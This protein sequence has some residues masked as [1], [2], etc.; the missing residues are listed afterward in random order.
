MDAAAIYLRHLHGASLLPHSAFA[1][2]CMP[3]PSHV[4][5]THREDAVFVGI[6]IASEAAERRG[7]LD[8]KIGVIDAF[9]GVTVKEVTVRESEHT[10]ACGYPFRVGESYLVFAR[11][12]HGLY[13]SGICSRT[14]PLA[15]A[16]DDLE[17]LRQIKTGRVTSRV[18]GTALR[19]QLS[20]NGG[21]W[22]R[23]CRRHD[24]IADC[25]ARSGRVARDP[26]RRDRPLRV[27]RTPSGRLPGRATVAVRT[28][29]TI[30]CRTYS[31]KRVRSRRHLVDRCDGR[32]ARRCRSYGR[33]KSNRAKCCRNRCP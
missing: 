21:Y 6:V 13:Y 10:A 25:G 7:E 20:L 1:C 16:T 3:P 2:S 22:L 29:G 30:S 31:R 15:V 26:D 23:G 9:K 5:P 11:H 17:M 4:V 8:F 12:R 24:R 28:E 14:Q 32:A 27:R 33:W 19:R 18:L